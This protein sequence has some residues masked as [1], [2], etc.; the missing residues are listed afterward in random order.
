MAER[1]KTLMSP[2]GPK[3]SRN[4]NKRRGGRTD[5]RT[6][7]PNRGGS[8]EGEGVAPPPFLPVQMRVL[9]QRIDQQVVNQ[10]T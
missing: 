6:D 4:G 10:V 5:R 2:L 1:R 9:F 8:I 7:S 3:W